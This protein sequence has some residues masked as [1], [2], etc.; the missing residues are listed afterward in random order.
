MGSN[1]FIGGVILMIGTVMG[2]GMLAM[3][4]VSA[5][6]GF[7]LAALTLLA[8]LMLS[9][10]TGFLVLEVNLAMPREAS[11][12]SSMAEKTLGMP[13]K[14][15]TWFSYLFLLYITV[16]AFIIGGSDIILSFLKG[17]FDI[18]IPYVPTAVI[19]TIVL[20]AAVF[21]ST[22]A[23]DYLN[24]SLF[25]IKGFLLVG[26]LVL[27]TPKIDLAKLA[28]GFSVTQ[29]K[30]AAMAIPS[31]LC[32]LCYQFFIPSLRLYIGDDY[33]KLKLIIVIGLSISTLFY[34][35]WLATSLGVIPLTGKSS[36][37]TLYQDHGMSVGKFTQ[38][39]VELSNNQ[40]VTKFI[41]GFT[42]VAMTTS[43]LGVSLGLFDFLADGFKR[44]D[45]RWGR[46]QTSLLTFIP[47][48]LFALLFPGA[49][50]TAISYS[51]VVQAVLCIILPV[52]MVYNL[53]KNGQ[54]QSS[55]RVN[56]GNP[57]FIA[58]LLC[59]AVLVVVALFYVLGRLPGL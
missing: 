3:P 39:T 47:P 14:I 43:F 13:G 53:R 55:Y 35:W 11:S 58:L 30:F 19:F 1:K 22:K 56:C 24:R 27:I 57:T 17:S 38:L 50:V 31:F 40:W 25:S 59:G 32:A 41:N 20:G 23:V 6:T 34:L 51:A 48:L 46:L 7:S 12:F 42:N 33:K 16:T 49:F 29:A 8:L 10:I 2:G 54:Y 18:T 15:A 9:V 26:F 36:F 4:I 28:S 44:K 45:N 5:S 37:T 52:L 21:W